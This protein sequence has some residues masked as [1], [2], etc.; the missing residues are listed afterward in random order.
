MMIKRKF[1]ISVIFMIHIRLF[2][3]YPIIAI[4]IFHPS[5]LKEKKKLSR[6]VFRDQDKILHKKKQKLCKL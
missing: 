4:S 1:D 6:P 2:I 3:I 5:F